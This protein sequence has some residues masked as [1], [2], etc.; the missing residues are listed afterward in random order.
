MRFGDGI[1]WLGKEG[2]EEKENDRE[3]RERFVLKG[4]IGRTTIE[5]SIIVKFS[6]F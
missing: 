4:I 2:G 3:K 5:F 6:L 1:G